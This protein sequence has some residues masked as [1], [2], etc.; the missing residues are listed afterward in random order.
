[1]S[2]SATEGYP[3]CV[4]AGSTNRERDHSQRRQGLFLYRNE[5]EASNLYPINWFPISWIHRSRS[6]SK[7]GVKRQRQRRMRYP[8]ST[9]S[10]ARESRNPRISNRGKLVKRG[11]KEKGKGDPDWIDETGQKS[12]GDLR[13]G[14]FSFM[15]LTR[16]PTLL[17]YYYGTSL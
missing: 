8:S 14:G 16:R 17:Q 1:M 11:K 13:N 12:F 9:F 5:P 4:A 15:V 7:E 6:Q 3:N 2:R 10:R